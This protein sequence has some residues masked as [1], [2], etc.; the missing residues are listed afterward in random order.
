[1]NDKLN[2][3]LPLIAALYK[4]DKKFLSANDESL[5][6]FL[7]STFYFQFIVRIV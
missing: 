5:E 4:K 2:S 7:C 6:S 3:H 1:M